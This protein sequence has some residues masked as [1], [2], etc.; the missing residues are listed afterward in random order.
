MNESAIVLLDVDVHEE[1][2]GGRS[3][4]EY[5]ER[6]AKFGVWTKH[7]RYVVP[8]TEVSSVKRLGQLEGS[9]RT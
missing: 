6:A 1:V 4:V 2:A 3:K 7:E 9:T 5:L 8:M